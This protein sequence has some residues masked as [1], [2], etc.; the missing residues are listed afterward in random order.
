MTE[1]LVCKPAVCVGEFTIYNLINEINGNILC[2]L[3]FL[4][5]DKIV[6]YNF[7]T[8]L[9]AK[10]FWHSKKWTIELY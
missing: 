10:G 1:L 5:G 2:N 8:T 4:N 9:G 3:N 6:L 7:S